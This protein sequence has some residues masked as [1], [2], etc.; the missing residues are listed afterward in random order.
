MKRS[1]R[2][3]GGEVR[4]A[5][6]SRAVEKAI[7]EIRS[8]EMGE[9]VM[10]LATRLFLIYRSIT[11]EGVR[12]TLEILGETVALNVQSVPVGYPAFDWTVPRE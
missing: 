2:L 4:A 9:A 6:A 7:Q 8:E 5:N 10:A 12:Q 1:Q 3:A 11:G